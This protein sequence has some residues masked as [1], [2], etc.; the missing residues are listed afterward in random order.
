MVTHTSQYPPPPPGAHVETTGAFADPQNYFAQLVCNTADAATSGKK[1]PPL[2]APGVHN[3][4]QQNTCGHAKGSKRFQERPKCHAP[5]T[6]PPTHLLIHPPSPPSV[7]HLAR[8]TA[9][10]VLADT[11]LSGPSSV[12]SRSDTTTLILV[13]PAPL[14]SCSY[15]AP[16]LARATKAWLGCG[17]GHSPSASPSH[18]SNAGPGPCS[19]AAEP[20][21]RGG[22]D[23]AV[24]AA[25]ERGDR[26]GDGDGDKDE[27]E[28][29]T[30]GGNRVER[31]ARVQTR[32]SPRLDPRQTPEPTLML[33]VTSKLE[34]AP[35]LAANAQ[36]RPLLLLPTWGGADVQDGPAPQEPRMTLA[37]VRLPVAGVS[38]A[39]PTSTPE[40]SPASGQ[41]GAGGGESRG[42]WQR[43]EAGVREQG[44]GS[45]SYQWVTAVIYDSGS[46]Q[47]GATCYDSCHTRPARARGP[48]DLQDIAKPAR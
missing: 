16:S 2:M 9:S 7:S 15:C 37:A 28:S 43:T 26:D 20:A 8:R 38:N 47:H 10:S 44:R 34:S 35:D 40:A 25:V 18:P 12:P 23:E 32:R 19:L 14:T 33:E 17:I 4:R 42:V 6:H 11:S 22:G 30:T 5:P 36:K 48:R 29:E 13:A 21:E 24:T 3:V 46:N 27:D 31:T 41:W 45:G 39:W 1:R